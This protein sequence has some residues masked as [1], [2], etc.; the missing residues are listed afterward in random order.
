MT[1]LETF[2]DAELV[3]H[4]TERKYPW[5]RWMTGPQVARKG[6]PGDTG[7]VFFCSPDSFVVMLRARARDASMKVRVKS[8]FDDSDIP[9]IAFEF[10]SPDPS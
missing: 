2:A 3:V 9:A 6:K 8:G 4:H 10:Y 1:Q 7:D 5:S